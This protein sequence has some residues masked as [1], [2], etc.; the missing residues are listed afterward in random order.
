MAECDRVDLWNY[1]YFYRRQDDEWA[2]R[3]LEK[4]PMM[5][6]TTSTLRCL[7]CGDASADADPWRCDAM[8]AGM[9]VCGEDLGMIP[10]C[11]QGVLDALAILGLRIQRYC[12]F[13]AGSESHG[14]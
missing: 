1:S 8:C 3:A 12:S 14:S 2:R 11:V 7:H 10:A 9:L 4:L 6:Q 5:Q 13:S